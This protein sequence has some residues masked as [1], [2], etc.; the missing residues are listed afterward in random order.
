[1]E[2]DVFSEFS[3]FMIHLDSEARAPELGIVRLLS[4]FSSALAR[5]EEEA[6]KDRK[7][8]PQRICHIR[9]TSNIV[10]I[11][12]SDNARQ[13]ERVLRGR[14]RDAINELPVA[15]QDEAWEKEFQRRLVWQRYYDRH[16]LEHESEDT[17][18]GKV[19]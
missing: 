14:V 7:L 9:L 13:A 12:S 1:M 15:K 18:S 19:V 4:D 17:A 16:E 2:R 10:S 11:V 6:I 3:H 5:L 8:A